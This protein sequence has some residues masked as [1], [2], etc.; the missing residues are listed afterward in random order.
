M[1]EYI[2]QWGRKGTSQE[3]KWLGLGKSC[4]PARRL[5]RLPACSHR[6]VAGGCVGIKAKPCYHF[7]WEYVPHLEGNC[8]RFVVVFTQVKNT[9]IKS[10]GTPKT[11]SRVLEYG[12][13]TPKGEWRP[14]YPVA[15]APIFV[16]PPQMLAAFKRV[17]GYPGFI[18]PLNVAYW[19]IAAATQLFFQPA[20]ER[21]G[22]LQAG[23]I[24]QMLGSCPRGESRVQIK[25]KQDW[26]LGNWP[27]EVSCR[28]HTQS[29]PKFWDSAAW[30][31]L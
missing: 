21:C 16:L 8:F 5:N 20:L 31:S 24:G 26:I 25:L 3:P 19:L 6:P 27:L 15:Y 2:L 29:L 22:T 4:P 10:T 11:N 18:W 1:E 17:L 13:R 30:T 23:W 12:Y 28:C 14:P 7:Y 9:T